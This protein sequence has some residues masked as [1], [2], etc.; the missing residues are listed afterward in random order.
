MN[1]KENK[2]L[3]T[4]CVVPNGFTKNVTENQSWYAL[5]ANAKLMVIKFLFRVA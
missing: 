1:V 4:V 2:P 3:F 5:A